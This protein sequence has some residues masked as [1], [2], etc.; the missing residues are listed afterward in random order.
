MTLGNGIG[1]ICDVSYSQFDLKEYTTQFI[2]EVSQK[3]T[4][5][6][7]ESLK[8]VGPGSA[9]DEMR[10]NEASIFSPEKLIVV[11][12]DEK[13]V[14]TLKVMFGVDTPSVSIQC[15]TGKIIDWDGPEEKVDMM[16]MMIGS[17]HESRSEDRLMVF[18][19][20]FNQWLEFGGS[21][22]FD[23]DDETSVYS[24]ALL[25]SF[26]NHRMVSARQIIRDV[27]MIPQVRNVSGH[28]VKFQTDDYL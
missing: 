2:N 8:I 4:F 25:E 21:L 27:N 20:V 26:P 3:D 15:V 1:E 7:T 19:R 5:A 12:P 23:L 28:A 18:Q 10:F 24:S 14:K 16:M 17:F 22:L 11:D 6:N 9:V 13:C